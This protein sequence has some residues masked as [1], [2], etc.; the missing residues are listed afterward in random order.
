MARDAKTDRRL[1][2]NR[3]YAD[4]MFYCIVQKWDAEAERYIDALY[5]EAEKTEINGPRMTSIY[6]D[7]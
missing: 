4:K 7:H 2:C 6:K 5:F 1:E 3:D